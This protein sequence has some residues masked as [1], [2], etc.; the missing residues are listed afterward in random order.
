MSADVTGETRSALNRR[1]ARG[2]AWM[3]GLRFADRAIGFVST[4]IL[5]RL[6]LPGDFGLVALA[7]SMIAAIGVFGEFGFE[8]AL[9]QNQKAD[10]RHYDTAW[11]LGLL[12]GAV[13]A[14]VIAVLAQPIARFFDEPRLTNVILVCALLLLLEGLYNIGT[15]A[16]RKDLTLHKEFV[17]RLAPRV[18]G[19]VVTIPVAFIFR[20][21][22]A[23]VCGTIAAGVLRLVLSYLMH[24][25]RPRLSLAAW[26]E[27]MGFSKWMLA[28]NIA[29][30]V[31]DKTSTFAIAKFLDATS[32]GV[33]SLASQIA[34]MASAELLAPIRQ[35]LFP[36]YAKLAHDTALLR[37]AFLDAY[38]IL[39]LI[40]LP[41]AIGIGL[42]AEY[43]IPLLL[44]PKWSDAIPLI[45]ILVISGGLLS[46][47][48]HVQPLYLAMNQPHLGAWASIGRAIVYIP[49]LVFA[50]SVYGIMGAAI[51]DAVCH[52][53]VLLGG[54]YLMHRLLKITV[55]DIWRA[56]W[57][58][59]AGC[60]LMV[61]SVGAIKWFP[62][63]PK[64]GVAGHTIL[65][66]TAVVIGFIAYVG[67]LLALWW[68]CGR[69]ANSAESHVLAYLF[70]GM[71]KRRLAGAAPPSDVGS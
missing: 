68:I 50:L 60:A 64:E 25:Y 58:S 49:L 14:A 18:A 16:F 2:A 7:I 63:V 67:T 19:V 27:I 30:F 56:C 4:I 33:F 26:R 22:W 47:S 11:T 24:R 35:A 42:T 45:E 31:N 29:G 32:V 36:G 43:S 3:V 46:L 9:I 52:L 40:A 69:P 17:Y 62:P 28:S 71:H 65:L 61:L 6:L 20:S 51:A 70:H 34:N 8:V 48:S 66:V 57:R 15:V 41:T 44:G 5:A 54:L 37:A 10:R 53:T 13:A 23:L 21:Y 59:L 12:R 1:I 39:V 38:G 55:A